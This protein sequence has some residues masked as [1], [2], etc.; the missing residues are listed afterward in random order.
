MDSFDSHTRRRRE[1]RIPSEFGAHFH[2]SPL[3]S[4]M[5]RFLLLIGAQNEIVPKLIRTNVIGFG[6]RKNGKQLEKKID[7]ITVF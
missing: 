4:A 1:E 7:Y 3:V 5:F 2:F 6:D